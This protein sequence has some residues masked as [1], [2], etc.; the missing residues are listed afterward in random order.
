[1][2]LTFAVCNQK[3][4]VSKTTYLHESRPAVWRN[5]G[6]KVLLVS[7]PTHG[8]QMRWN[9]TDQTKVLPFGAVNSLLSI[10]QEITD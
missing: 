3:G 6:Y 7:M 4:G 2:A 5:V 10:H 1:M 8:S 9:A